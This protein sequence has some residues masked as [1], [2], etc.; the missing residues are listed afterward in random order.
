LRTTAA[1]NDCDLNHSGS[2][3]ISIAGA[4]KEESYDQEEGH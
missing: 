3:E 2:H 4:P 1:G